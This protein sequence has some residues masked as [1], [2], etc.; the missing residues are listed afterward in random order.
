MCSVRLQAA[1]FFNNAKLSIFNK[2]TKINNKVFVLHT[3]IR[4]FAHENSDK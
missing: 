2:N 1:P 4:I 3:F